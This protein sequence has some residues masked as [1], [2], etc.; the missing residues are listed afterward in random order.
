[1]KTITFTTL[2]IAIAIAMFSFIPEKGNLSKLSEYP[3]IL[4]NVM[5]IKS[6]SFSNFLRKF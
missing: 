2:G 4:E 1:M 3:S 5:F 6:N